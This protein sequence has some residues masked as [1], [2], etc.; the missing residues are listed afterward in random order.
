M[1]Y[2]KFRQIV[3]NRLEEQIE[4]PNPGSCRGKTYKHIIGNP[5]SNSQEQIDIVNKQISDTLTVINVLFFHFSSIV[6][7]SSLFC[8]G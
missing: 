8:F 2:N 4:N 3:L 1:K 7:N 6:I 5:K